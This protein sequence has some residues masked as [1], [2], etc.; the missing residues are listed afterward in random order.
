M[1]DPYYSD[2]WVTIYHGD[3]QEILPALDTPVDVILTDPP[4][5]QG[6][7]SN[8]RSHPLL[9]NI[10]GDEAVNLSWV[11]PL[12]RCHRM[13]GA[14]YAFAGEW[15]VGPLS[16]ALT[17]A[18]YGLNRLLVWD[19]GHMSQ[20]DLANWGLRTEF[21]VYASAGAHASKGSRRSRLRG[22]RSPNLL[23]VPK[24]DN[25][26]L[27]HPAE[28]PRALLELLV[29]RSTTWDEV[30]LDP[31]MGSGTTLRA[32]K[33]LGRKAIGIEVEERYCEIAARRMGQGVMPL[34]GSGAFAGVEW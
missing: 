25:R 8:Y 22:P 11:G 17:Q 7:Q 18:R 26:L 29:V 9:D 10:T 14:L 19:K 15:L 28:K 4:Y 23:N 1:I 30:V 16:E 13:G 6:F 3:C 5:G 32:A 20:G 12:S 34:G 31:F 33:D 21:I 2:E 27:V 24:V